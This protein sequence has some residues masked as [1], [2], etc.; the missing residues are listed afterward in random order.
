MEICHVIPASHGN[1]SREAHLYDAVPALWNGCT[2]LI[3]CRSS[4]SCYFVTDAGQCSSI[5]FSRVSPGTQMI[6][7]QSMDTRSVL[8]TMMMISR[9][10]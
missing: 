10:F 5:V 2:R 3:D 1:A 8:I 7:I 4:S 6:V 9:T